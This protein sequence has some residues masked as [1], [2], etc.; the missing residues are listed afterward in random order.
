MIRWEVLKHGFTSIH[1][2]PFGEQWITEQMTTWQSLLNDL[3][4]F[5]LR[6]AVGN[7]W[8]TLTVW[9]TPAGKIMRFPETDDETIS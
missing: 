1:V 6:V 7:F 2:Y 5:S 3:K 8:N 4:L 9:P